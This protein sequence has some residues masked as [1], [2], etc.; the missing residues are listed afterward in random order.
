MSKI[1]LKFFLKTHLGYFKFSIIPT[2]NRNSRKYA[3]YEID[4]TVKG[5]LRNSIRIGELDLKPSVA[6]VLSDLLTNQ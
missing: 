4:S 1:Q 3:H 2:M 6:K 5:N